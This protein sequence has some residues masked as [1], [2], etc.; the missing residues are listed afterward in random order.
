[1]DDA[2]AAE[3]RA[4]EWGLA[5]MALGGVLALVGPIALT[6]AFLV[7]ASGFTGMNR[8]DRFLAGVGGS[9]AGLALI[10]FAVTGV[11]FGGVAV[12]AA[13]RA[14]LPAARGVVGIMLNAFAAFVFLT[15][16]GAWLAALA[17]H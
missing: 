6:L 1:M 15:G 11:V 17:G 12:G 7:H 16:L 14:G 5:A 8:T 9:V 10:G 2:T 4:T 3:R 13:R